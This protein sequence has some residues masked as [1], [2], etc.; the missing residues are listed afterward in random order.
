MTRKGILAVV[1][2]NAVVLAAVMGTHSLA[3]PRDDA[4]AAA[5]PG[6]GAMPTGVR[7]GGPP[8]M[9]GA[10]GAGQPGRP[11]YPGMPP[12][13][14]MMGPF[15]PTKME[16]VARMA[17]LIRQMQRICFEPP[18]AGL[19]AI[20]GLKDEVPRKPDA[21]IKDLE[22]QLEKTRTLGFRNAIRMILKDLYKAQGDNEKVLEHLRK[23]LEENDQA[24]QKGQQKPKE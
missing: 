22:S 21:I 3:A 12:G 19:V 7:P 5:R 16:R 24:L 2:V 9:A 18:T 6:Q 1:L 11:G 10:S 23:M 17:G 20:G 4:P 15:A 14:G 8:P 13:E